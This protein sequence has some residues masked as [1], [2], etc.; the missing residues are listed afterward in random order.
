MMRG[1]HRHKIG[2]TP[3]IASAIIIGAVLVSNAGLSLPLPSWNCGKN[4]HAINAVLAG[5]DVNQ[6]NQ[7]VLRGRA[8]IATSAVNVP[9]DCIVHVA[10]RT[11]RDGEMHPRY[12]G[13]RRDGGVVRSPRPLTAMS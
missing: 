12:A 9:A 7:S 10:R 4:R 11:R 1:N 8:M 13:V 3:M 5:S 6:A 2:R